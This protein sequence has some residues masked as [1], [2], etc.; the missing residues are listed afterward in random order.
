MSVT[1]AVAREKGAPLVI[2]E[3]ELDELRSNEVRVRMVGSGIC[4]TDAV[5]RDGIYP[6]PLP[7]VFG[8]EG[9]GVVEAVGSEVFTVEVGDH[10]VLGPAYCGKCTSC[11][12]GEP[13]YCQFAFEEM[14]GCQRRDGTTGFSKDGERVGSHFFGQSSFA[15]HANVVENSVIVVDK[16]APLELLGPLGCG[17]NTGAGAVLNEMRPQPGTSIAVFGTGAVGFGALMAAAAASCTTIVGVD[18]HDSRLELARELG[19][20]HTVNSK[21]QNLHEEL[22]RITGGQGLNFALDTTAVPA[23]I[24]S[25]AEALGKRG[26]LVAVGAAAPGTEVSFE[27]GNS[28]LKGW[29]F[30]TVIEGS[31]VPQLFIPRLVELWKQGRFP[32]DK[33]VQTYSL[34]DINQGF[35]DSASGSVIK[36]VLV[37]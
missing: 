4:H 6:V 36:P 10:V 19:A 13:M 23:V 32:F 3:L 17:L 37:Y 27:V 26:E 22:D 28:L 12:A 14:F 11:R 8:H 9:S 5:A 21:T 1:A 35:E 30:K 15:S 25:A 24:S 2:E 18:I 33:L 29:T 16:D 20:T 31:S 7:A 34:D